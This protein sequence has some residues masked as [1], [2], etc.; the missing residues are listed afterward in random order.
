METKTVENESETV[1]VNTASGGF[2]RTKFTF[3]VEEYVNQK[4]QRKGHALVLKKNGEWLVGFGE[5]KAADLALWMKESG[6][7]KVAEAFRI[8]AIK[9]AALRQD[10]ARTGKTVSK[11]LESLL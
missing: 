10:G 2:S 7:E 5:E 1:A 3:A 8:G 11:T 9:L 4:S 6:P